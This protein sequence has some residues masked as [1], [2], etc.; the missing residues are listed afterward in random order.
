M[1]GGTTIVR[2]DMTVYATDEEIRQD[3]ELGETK[4]EGDCAGDRPAWHRG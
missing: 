2:E 3:G 1:S 4:C